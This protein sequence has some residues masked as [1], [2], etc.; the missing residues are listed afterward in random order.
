MTETGHLDE[1]FHGNT[2]KKQSRQLTLAA[3]S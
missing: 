3:D 2:L 1:D